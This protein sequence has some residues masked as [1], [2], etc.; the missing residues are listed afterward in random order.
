MSMIFAATD[1]ETL[2]NLALGGSVVSI[3]IALVLMKVVSSIVGK[4]ISTA[5]FVA[6][7]LAGYSQRAEITDCVDKV[8]AQATTSASVDTTCTFFGQD[9]T[10]KVPLPAK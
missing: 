9:V 4:V 2:K 10:I 7:A 6:I 3:V 8:K 5:V 1:P